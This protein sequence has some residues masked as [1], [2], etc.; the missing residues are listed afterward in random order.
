MAFVDNKLYVVGG[1]QSLSKEQTVSDN[2]LS[3]F[4]ISLTTCTCTAAQQ[5]SRLVLSCS[6]LN[7]AEAS[8][9]QAPSLPPSG[10]CSLSFSYTISHNS[11]LYFPTPSSR[12]D[13]FLFPYSG[14]LLLYGGVSASGTP[15]N[16]VWRFDIAAASWTLCR[17]VDY[18]APLA[19]H[20]QACFTGTTIVTVGGSGPCRRLTSSLQSIYAGCVVAA[21]S[22]LTLAWVY[23]STDASVAPLYHH[24]CA[25]VPT[26]ATPTFLLVGGTLASYGDPLAPPP[27]VF[28]R[29]SI[30]HL[31][32][33]SS[34]LPSP[35]LDAVTPPSSNRPSLS[36]QYAGTPKERGVSPKEYVGTPKERGVSPKEYAGTPKER[37]TSPRERAS[38][39]KERGVSPKE[40]VGTPKERT[41]SPRERA[42]TP[43]ER[44]N[45]AVHPSPRKP[46]RTPTTTSGFASHILTP[47]QFEDCYAPPAEPYRPSTPNRGRSK[48]PALS[49]HHRTLSTP[50][51]CVWTCDVSPRLS[52]LRPAPSPRLSR[53]RQP[54]S[55]EDLRG[56]VME[57]LFA[58]PK[59]LP[60]PPVFAETSSA[61]SAHG[62]T[63]SNARS[64]GIACVLNNGMA[65]SA[66]SVSDG[67]T[68]ITT[69]ITTGITTGITSIGG[70]KGGGKTPQVSVAEED[71]LND[72]AL[73]ELFDQTMEKIKSFDA[74]I[75]GYINETVSLTLRIQKAEVMKAELEQCIQNS[76]TLLRVSPDGDV[77]V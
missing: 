49:K 16:D 66:G 12:E 77:R 56:D 31:T 34:P 5:P 47:D 71:S 13:C 28:Q 70:D 43:R 36:M 73:L 26:L 68:G 44:E 60:R 27:P 35:V 32:A 67:P 14:S 11:I 55:L 33:A 7:A 76:S 40:Y 45:V 6:R 8:N 65:R 69:D 72:D 42:S 54:T 41:T 29:L 74:T 1:V 30:P 2:T 61:A 24:A 3:F 58:T 75:R 18:I 37:T 38:T 10:I 23:S 50:I 53:I 17:P 46:S 62:P 39:P 51:K 48:A 4:I 20:Q 59:K 64:G 9:L 52:S 19:L 21:F 57:R 15:L 63:S 25:P 22:L